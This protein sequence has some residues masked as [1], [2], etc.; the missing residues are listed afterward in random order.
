MAKQSKKLSKLS[1]RK[2]KPEP[3]VNEV[4]FRV[5]AESTAEPAQL[6]PT[7]AM[8]SQVMAE[9]GR[10]GGKIGGRARA[11]NLTPE[12]RRGIA[13]KAARSRWDRAQHG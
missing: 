3:D 6:K 7:K 12:Q 2:R 11:A 10:K 13:L 1:K 4:A 9:L 5:V 8:V